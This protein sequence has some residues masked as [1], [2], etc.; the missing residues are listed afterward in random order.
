MR[1]SKSALTYLPP[2]WKWPSLFSCIVGSIFLV[3]FVTGFLS[4]NITISRLSSGVGNLI[5]FLSRAIPPDVTRVTALSGSI[6]QTFQMVIVGTFSGIVCSLPIALI[7][8]KKTSPFTALRYSVRAIVSTMRTVPDLIW[9]L[10]FVIS[11]G[12]GP[13]AG[14]LAIMVDTIGFCGRF[15]AERID[16]VDQG[17]IHALE[18]TGA[19]RCGVIAGAVLPLSFPSMVA[20]SLYSVEKGIRSAVVLGLVGAGGIG[21]ELSTAMS[22][23]RFDEAMMIIL[24]ILVVVLVVEQVSNKIRT[25]VL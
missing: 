7:A 18:S 14:I 19:G 2:R 13:L 21:V 4:A 22:L 6:L 25:K 24:L 5:T 16:E 3:F 10:I 15:F 11:V 23:R 1:N 12:L 9:A 8:S 17:P 20:T